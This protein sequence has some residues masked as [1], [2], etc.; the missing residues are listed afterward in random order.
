MSLENEINQRKFRSENQKARINILYTYS[1]LSEKI[2]DIFE[3]WDI[4][5]KQFNILRILRGEGKPL[6]TLQIRERMLDKMSDTSRI[7][8]R[9]IL[10][11]L[12]KKTPNGEDRRL[13]D[14]VITAK[15]RK[16]LEKMDPLEEQMDEIMG[17][18]SEEETSTLNQLLDKLRNT[19][20]SFVLTLLLALPVIG[21]SQTADSARRVADSAAQAIQGAPGAVDSTEEEDEPLHP[22]PNEF[23]YTGTAVPRPKY[24]FRAAWIASVENIDWPYRKGESVDSQKAQFIRQLEMHKRNGM[25][26]VVVQIR[27]AADAFYNSPYEPWSEWLTGVQGKAPSP[28][29]DPLQWMI[30]ETHKRGMEFHAW[31]N[32]YRAV[33][34]LGRVERIRHGRH[35]TTRIIGESS[36][37]PDHITRQHPEWFVKFENTLYFDPGNKDVQAYVIKVIRDIVKRYDIDALHFDDYFY[38]YDIVEGSS[39]MDFPDR[40]SFAKYGNGM[41]ISDWRRS[42]VDSVMLHISRAIKEEK[43][44]CKFGISPFGVW[45]NKSRDPE[46]SDTHAGQTNYDN[47][48]ANILLWLDKGWI[49]YVAPQLYWEFS[50]S[51]APYGVLLDW[52]SRHTYGRQCYIGLGIY[53]AGS[54]P[55][56]RDRTQLTRQ[57]QAQRSYPG[58]NG[59]IYF[60]SRS[61]ETNPYGWCDSLQNHY[62]NY[63]ALIPPM[64]WID[65]VRP[66]QPLFHVESNTKDLSVTA[67]VT[68]GDPSDSLRGYALYRA[69]SANVNIDSLPAS[70]FIPYDPV[71]AF[72]IH[73]GRSE[74]KGKVYYYFVTAIS[75]NNVESRPV[76]LLLSNFTSAAP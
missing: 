62:Y 58:V 6:S 26:A 8:D 10:K 74:E 71:A 55:A 64:D 41:K 15:G 35:Y 5:V 16:L 9:L 14:V 39:S 63:P 32:P 4:T 44:Y 7:V 27:P 43:P 17:A 49:D 66:H 12:V 13:V 30:E 24:E 19:A 2:D 57:I 29:Y 42:N 52:W 18:L 21:F 67:W 69:D 73:N 3:R 34:S 65:T 72:T 33:K 36:I 76:P 45:R 50:F 25:N 28:Y 48:Y 51:H 47:L 70:D 61:F 11:G 59:A 1:W 38:P 56:W 20:G 68:K 46:G 22:I 60:S 23:S 31:C 75:R 53:R 40:A 37:A 54:N